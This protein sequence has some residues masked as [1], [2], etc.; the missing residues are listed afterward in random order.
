MHRKSKSIETEK[1]MVAWGWSW[2]QRVHCVR[3]QWDVIFLSLVGKGKFAKIKALLTFV[4]AQ[5]D[6]L[7]KT[8]KPIFH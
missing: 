2:E 8:V 3:S 7:M 6:F 5:K 4:N 1:L